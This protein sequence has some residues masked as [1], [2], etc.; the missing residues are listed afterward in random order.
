M[1]PSAQDILNIP[2]DTQTSVFPSF[3][4]TSA[5]EVPTVLYT[6]SPKRVPLSGGAFPYGPFQGVPSPTSFPGLF[7]FELGRRPNSKAKSPGNE[8]GLPPGERRATENSAYRLM[9]RLMPVA[10]TLDELQDAEPDEL[11]MFAQ[12]RPTEILM[13]L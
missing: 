7:P 6:S 9:I 13:R 1:S 8:V 3:F 12:V 5:R 4:Y 10:F 11:H 2:F